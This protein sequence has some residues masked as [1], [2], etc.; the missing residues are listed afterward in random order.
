MSLKR[1]V[2]VI[3]AFIVIILPI[4]IL[5]SSKVKSKVKKIGILRNNRFTFKSYGFYISHEGHILTTHYHTQ[6]LNSIKIRPTRTINAHLYKSSPLEGYTIFKTRVSSMDQIYRLGDSDS[7][8]IGDQVT[9]AGETRGQILYKLNNFNNYHFPCFLADFSYT[10][11]DMGKPVLDV[12]NRAIGMLI[13]YKNS[14]II[15]PINRIKPLIKKPLRDLQHRRPGGYRIVYI[16][17]VRATAKNAST[18][19]MPVK[20]YGGNPD[21]NFGSIKDMAFDQDNN[22]YVIDD[23]YREVKKIALSGLREEFTSPRMVQPKTP[24]LKMDDKKTPSL[25]GKMKGKPVVVDK[26]VETRKE[27][28]SHRPINT[29]KAFIKQPVSLTITANNNI[30]ILDHARRKIVLFNQDLKNVYE[31][32]YNNVAKTFNP[33]K[34]RAFGNELFVVSDVHRLYHLEQDKMSLKIKAIHNKL[35]RIEFMDLAQENGLFYWLDHAHHE[36]RIMDKNRVVSRRFKIQ[37]KTPYPSSIAIYKGIIYVFDKESGEISLYD[38]KGK[39]IR[40][41]SGD[42]SNKSGSPTIM[43]ISPAGI[44]AI[45]Y[46]G[47]PHIRLFQLN[48]T[49]IKILSPF[50]NQDREVENPISICIDPLKRLSII[51]GGPGVHLYPTENTKIASPGDSSPR[52]IKYLLKNDLTVSFRGIASDSKGLFFL[53]DTR[54]DRVFAFPKTPGAEIMSFSGKELGELNQP[55]QLAYS[56]GY[57]Y[58]ADKENHRIVKIDAKGILQKAFPVRTKNGRILY[59]QDLTVSESGFVYVL[60]QNRVLKFDTDGKYLTEFRVEQGKD[61]YLGYAKGI[62]VS[63][64]DDTLYISDTYNNRILRYDDKGTLIDYFGRLGGGKVTVAKQGNEEFNRPW[65]LIIHLG[66]LYVVDKGNHRVIQ[67]AIQSSQGQTKE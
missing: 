36:I 12:N 32:N 38:G 8:D 9:L 5:A 19:P 14:V 67:Y 50:S 54:K 49:L 42:I 11:M 64:G 37:A 61:S 29:R 13:N 3:L 31:I 33:I 25:K 2:L 53:S 16:D 10:M 63:D 40:Y 39:F 26:S 51:T 4:Y 57:L 46:E 56:K 52:S 6:Q 18:I 45:A 7:V 65:D 59:P 27:K 1:I 43:R 17:K 55:V 41:W 44:L 20:E 15:I 28:V 62:A 23:V 66:Q 58:I 48:G 35:A 60:A 47:H 21:Y 30:Y 34:V 24:S 22:L